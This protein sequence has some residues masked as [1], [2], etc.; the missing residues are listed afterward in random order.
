[1]KEHEFDF[2]L[3]AVCEEHAKYLK[4]IYP[5]LSEH[6]DE[7]NEILDV[8]KERYERSL[9]RA[10]RTVRTVLSRETRVPTEKM[11]ELYESQGVT[12]ELIQQVAK[13]EG[14]KVELPEDFYSQLTASHATE[15]PAE[16]VEIDAPETQH[17]YYK[18]PESREFTAKVVK[19][20][21][22]QGKSWTILDRTLFYGEKG[23]QD[24]DTGWLDDQRVND[25]QEIGNVTLHQ[26]DEPL[27]QGKTVKGTLDWERRVILRNHHTCTHIV[28]GA[29]RRVLGDHVWQAGAW[30]GVDKAHLDI[31]HY[32]N[33]TQEQVEKVEALVNKVIKEDRPVT[34]QLTPRIKAEEKYGFRLYQGGAVPAAE[35]FIVN[36]KDWDV[37]ACGGTHTSGTGQIGKAVIVGT[38][39][40]QDGIV[41]VHFKAGAAAD[42]Y[43]SKMDELAS[44]AAKLL[45]VKKADVPKAV[46]KLVSDWK[47]KRKQLESLLEENA[48]KQTG[49]MKPVVLKGMKIYT[50]VIPNAD[51][52]VLRAVSL[53]LSA[54]DSLVFLVSDKGP[55]FASAGKK[56]L[57][58]GVNAGQL[59]R[60]AASSRKGGGGGPPEKG[61]GMIRDASSLEKLLS[62]VREKAGKALK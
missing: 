4:P 51:M 35:L 54:D 3:G 52:Q 22:Y 41:R 24:H 9:D 37:E 44:E 59:V 2:E 19:S 23:G 5:S 62:E 1:M 33:L 32:E 14:K 50:A 21:D 27:D 34:Q 6:L 57:E 47:A 61:E 13:E 40:I 53:Q 11:V 48:G 30:K 28:N 39:R 20:L 43:L 15:K 38:E 18:E 25:V 16:F 46:K 8:E 12:P 58:R 49:E 60:E 31:T 56:L 42:A 29:C 7:I 10:R 17:L 36:V 45:D 26:V 55:V